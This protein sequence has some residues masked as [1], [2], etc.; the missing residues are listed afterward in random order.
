MRSL[1]RFSTRLFPAAVGFRAQRSRGDL[2]GRQFPEVA[3][4]GYC[5]RFQVRF[6]ATPVEM[7]GTSCHRCHM[8][9]TCPSAC[10]A[11]V[12]WSATLGHQT[13]SFL[14]QLPDWRP[15]SIVIKRHVCRVCVWGGG[16][17]RC[18]TSYPHLH[19][20]I[21]PRASAGA[22]VPP[23]YSRPLVDI[24]SIVLTTLTAEIGAK[25]KLA[26]LAT[27]ALCAA[28]DLAWWPRGQNGADHWTM[29]PHLRGLEVWATGALSGRP[30]GPPTHS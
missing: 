1:Q 10:T 14:P 26:K 4:V 18:L 29:V 8:R 7:D 9:A 20:S 24:N 12:L 16:D 15:I 19:P 5:Y 30:F 27:P 28:I 21:S 3:T 13:T 23:R 17:H 22:V 25:P 11:M 6:L 2:H